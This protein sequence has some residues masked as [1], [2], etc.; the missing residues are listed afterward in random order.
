MEIEDRDSARPPARDEMS[1]EEFDAMMAVGLAQ[2][3][4]GQSFLVD[5]VFSNLNEKLSG[6]M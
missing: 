4:E 1:T 5:E 6:Q 3:K 2:A